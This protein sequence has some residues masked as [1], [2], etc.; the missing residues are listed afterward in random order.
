MTPTAQPSRIQVI[1][2]FR[3]IAILAVMAYHYTVRWPEFYGYSS[4]YSELFRIGQYGVHLFFVV[5]GLV[6]TMTVIRSD[7]AFQFAVRRAARLYPAFVAAAVV[8]F[9]AMRFFG[10]ARFQFSAWDLLAS[11]TMDARAIGANY[12]DGAYWSLAV[13]VKFYAYVA[14]A[15]SIL[16]DRFWLGVLAVALLSTLPL[17]STWAYVLIADWWPY[18]LLGMSGWY[19]IY[20]KKS[21]Q[22]IALGLA[23]VFLY[24]LHQPAGMLVD[25]LIWSLA[26]GMLL[27]LKF[28]PSWAPLPVRWLAWVGSISYSLY[29]LH[30]NM[31]VTLIGRLTGIGLP[32][33]PAMA[34]AAVAMMAIAHF[35]FTYIEKPG[36]RFVMSTYA[37]IRGSDRP[38]Q[39]ESAPA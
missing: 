31:G 1:D 17:G 24:I 10:P 23:S 21:L 28:S 37:R 7:S 25:V 9:V 18:L 2:A 13:E 15:R 29:L 6:I 36:A 11:L 38:S 26:L 33:I 30:Q 39:P 5:S 27:L 20:E 12:V 35:S 4:S 8:T 16:K 34:V 19:L 22:G 14:L 32:D 3:G